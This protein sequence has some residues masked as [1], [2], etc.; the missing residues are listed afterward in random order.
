MGKLESSKNKFLSLTGQR[1]HNYLK[2]DKPTENLN[3]EIAPPSHSMDKVRL[4]WMFLP[5]RI[6]WGSGQIGE[7]P[8]HQFLPL[9]LNY[10]SAAALASGSSKV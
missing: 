2:M 10:N 1:Y 5:E 8:G 4:V 9:Q 7:I 6:S 3:S